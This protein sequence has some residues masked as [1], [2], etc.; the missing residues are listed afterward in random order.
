[1]MEG[2]DELLKQREQSSKQR[3]EQMIDEYFDDLGLSDVDAD[4]LSFGMEESGI[5]QD[6]DMT[7]LIPRQLP[8][9]TVEQIGLTAVGNSVG[10]ALTEAGEIDSFEVLGVPLTDKMYGRNAE[11]RGYALPAA[12]TPTGTHGTTLAD[13]N[14]GYSIGSHRT[15]VGDSQIVEQMLGMDP[16]IE[17]LRELHDSR[18]N[19]IVESRGDFTTLQQRML[20]EMIDE[21]QRPGFVGFEYDDGK[22]I[23]LGHNPETDTYSS[24]DDSRPLEL[25]PE[26]LS[27]QAI[28]PPQESYEKLVFPI[29]AHPDVGYML[30]GLENEKFKTSATDEFVARFE[31]QGLKFPFIDASADGKYSEEVPATAIEELNQT[32]YGSSSSIG[33]EAMV[34]NAQPSVVVKHKLDPYELGENS[35]EGTMRN[36]V[37]EVYG[38]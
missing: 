13:I 32:R 36:V 21:G 37:H 12:I 2:V 24:F 25:E 5:T 14:D 18:S 38:K 17:N 10:S 19:G 23:G 9:D 1:M 31:D 7:F 15:R 34:L 4:W 33:T 8:T 26:E 28:L 29:A 27:D 3:Q 30:K 22:L 16:E 20:S 6:E 11:K 35:F